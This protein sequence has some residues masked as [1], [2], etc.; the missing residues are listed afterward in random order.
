[1]LVTNLLTWKKNMEAF[2]SPI[3]A[4]MFFCCCSSKNVTGSLEIWPWLGHISSSRLIYS[5]SEA[6]EDSESTSGNKI[7]TEPNGSE[8]DVSTWCSCGKCSRMEWQI[9]NICCQAIPRVKWKP[10]T[11]VLR[12][13]RLLAQWF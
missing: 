13:G 7:S 1:M 4:G 3:V 10:H 11:D 2:K 5:G 6:E 9:E 12:I 8:D